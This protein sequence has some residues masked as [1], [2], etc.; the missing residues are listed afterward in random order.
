MA[1]GLA[2]LL[3]LALAAGTA[4]ATSTTHETGVDTTED[5]DDLAGELEALAEDLADAVE[6]VDWDALA[7]EAAALAA[8]AAAAA[9]ELEKKWVC[10]ECCWNTEDEEPF[11]H[12][13]DNMGC[14]QIYGHREWKEGIWMEPLETC[15]RCTDFCGC[16][17][18]GEAEGCKSEE[19]NA[20]DVNVYF[21]VPAFVVLF[22]ESLEV[23]LVLVIILQFLKKTRDKETIT[24]QQYTM[25]R[26]EVYVGAGIGF[27]A[28]I[29]LGV[30]ILALVSFA[31]QDVKGETHLILEG[32]L[33]LITSAI[34]SFMAVNFY[35]MMYAKEAHERKLAKYMVQA[36]ES[37]TAARDDSGP[38][39]A[40]FAK[41]HTFFKFAFVT[42][43]REGLESILFLSAIAV[44]AKD[45]SSLPIPMISAIVLARIVGWCFFTGTQRMPVEMF[46]KF[47]A[48]LLLFIAAGFFSSSTHN[49]Q[50]LGVFG[51]W[52]PRDDR[53]WQNSRVFDA[54]ECCN[55]M[56]NR[57]WVFM[58]A[59]FGWQDQP[60]PLE[61]FAYG[62][63]WVLAVVLGCLMLR[64]AKRQLERMKESWRQADEQKAK[65]AEVNGN[66]AAPPEFIAE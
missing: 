53:P 25:F 13:P 64:R 52:T 32:V 45:L 33:M 15:T 23:V 39:T 24:A 27:L 57:F 65:D 29:A 3:A 38:S 6:D 60:T 55:D 20:S 61:F 62:L 41:K 37:S 17:W 5:A 19:K 46:M 16:R 30:G 28:C 42:G 35:K 43:L 26:R 7:A 48:M 21:S 31:L 10:D 49:F 40:S 12:N 18:C 34:L 11:P 59:M 36:L 2:L 4:A 56:T 63:Y 58:R 14:M 22:R 50:E 54:R 8:A 44:D 47:S 66:G 9:N 51:T 1:R